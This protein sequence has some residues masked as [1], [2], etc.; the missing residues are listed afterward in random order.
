ML[1]GME[2]NRQ[3]AHPLSSFDEQIGALLDQVQNQASIVDRLLA[4]PAPTGEGRE[5]PEWDAAVVRR[6]ERRLAENLR[7]AIN[8]EPERRRA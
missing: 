1:P 3:D 4:M 7:E 6:L 8:S 5:A 2:Q